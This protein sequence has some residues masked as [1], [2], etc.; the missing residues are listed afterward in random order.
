ME[1]TK[2]DLT[3]SKLKN[4]LRINL[5]SRKRASNRVRYKAK[6]D[7]NLLKNDQMDSELK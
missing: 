5:F 1:S 2:Y 7:H 4:P 6:N 3:F